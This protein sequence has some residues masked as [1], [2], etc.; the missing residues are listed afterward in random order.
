MELSTLLFA[1]S[2]DTIPEFGNQQ[3]S[4]LLIWF[5]LDICT[6]VNGLLFNIAIDSILALGFT[7]I[8]IWSSSRIV[9]RWLLVVA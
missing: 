3:K 6:G 2:V 7:R 1:F 9:K 8:A 4:V 5:W